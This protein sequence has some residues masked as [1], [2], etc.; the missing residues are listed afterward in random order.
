MQFVLR[1]GL[2]LRNLLFVGFQPLHLSV[3]EGNLRFYISFRRNVFCEFK[4]WFMFCPNPI[5]VVKCH[6]TS[7]MKSQQKFNKP[8]S[9]PV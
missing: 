4:L 5:I 8:L 9:Y 2:A 6:K 3:W 7:L 1:S